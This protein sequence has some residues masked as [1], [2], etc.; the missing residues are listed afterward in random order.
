MLLYLLRWQ[1]EDAAREWL[2]RQDRKG[3]IPSRFT[4]H[5]LLDDARDEYHKNRWKDEYDDAA[6]GKL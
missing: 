3:L 4:P 6:R 1:D 5:D 2:E